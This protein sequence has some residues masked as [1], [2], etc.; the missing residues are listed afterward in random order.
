MKHIYKITYPNGKIYVGKDLTGSLSYFGS[1]HEATLRA[2][3]T[4]EQMRDFTIRKTILWESASADDV[5]VN[6][7]E[8]ALIRELRS[9]D[10]QIGYNRWPKHRPT[11]QCTADPADDASSLPIASGLST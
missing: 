6:Q 4:T 7:R 3:F 1:V 5:E 8:V 2:D 9:N 10:P 11:G